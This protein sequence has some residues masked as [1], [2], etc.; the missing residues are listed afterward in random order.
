[1]FTMGYSIFLIAAALLPGLS[2][3]W[4]LRRP[5]STKGEGLPVGGIIL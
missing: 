4:F 2:A 5:T 3:A 1:M